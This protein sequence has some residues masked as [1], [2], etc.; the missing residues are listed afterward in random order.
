MGYLIADGFGDNA[1][2]LAFN[3]QQ[4]PINGGTGPSL[5]ATY[6]INTTSAPNWQLSNL[7]EYYNVAYTPATTSS[8]TF[9]TGSFNNTNFNSLYSRTSARG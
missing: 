7:G 8:P 6:A 4:V 5:A 2:L 3:Q 9:A 1:S